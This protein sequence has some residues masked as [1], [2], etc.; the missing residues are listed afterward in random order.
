MEIKAPEFVREALSQSVKR[1]GKVKKCKIPLIGEEAQK[2][3]LAN[4]GKFVR[5]NSEG[6]KIPG[7]FLIRESLVLPESPWSVLQNKENQITIKTVLFE[8]I[9]EITNIKDFK[10][11]LINGIGPA[12]AFGCGLLSVA[13]IWS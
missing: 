2:T 4:K 3:W 6:E 8:G 11:T 13:R 1:K 10:H 9:L 12:K 5:N 7:G